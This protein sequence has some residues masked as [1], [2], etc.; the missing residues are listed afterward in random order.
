M[1]SENDDLSEHIPQDQY[2]HIRKAMMHLGRVDDRKIPVDVARYV[3]DT[4]G[5]LDS[6]YSRVDDER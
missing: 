4:Y 2:E 6:L 1:Q 5:K 3:E